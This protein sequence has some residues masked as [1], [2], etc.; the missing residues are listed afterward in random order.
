[1]IN[2]INAECARRSWQ[3][4]LENLR[5]MPV[6]LGLKFDGV[7]TDDD[8]LPSDVFKKDE[9][10]DV[11]FESRLENAFASRAFERVISLP[12]AFQQ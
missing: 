11:A 1:M 5:D 3:P 9:F 12:S 2:A 8:V 10:E 7:P 4:F 6:A